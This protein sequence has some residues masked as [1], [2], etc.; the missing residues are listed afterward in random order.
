MGKSIYKWMRT[1]GIPILGN[2]HMVGNE[3]PDVETAG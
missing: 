2:L 1:G 3:Y